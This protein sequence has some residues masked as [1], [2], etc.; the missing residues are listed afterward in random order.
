MIDAYILQSILT[1]VKQDEPFD[2]EDH[3]LSV[4][5]P[6]AVEMNKMSVQ[7][8][9][10]LT[11]AKSFNADWTGMLFLFYVRQIHLKMP[12]DIMN[13]ASYS[14]LQIVKKFVFLL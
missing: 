10:K 9:D 2:E 13:V 12:T 14:T 5:E 3:I 6:Q 7:H 1:C 4:G 8:I 11:L